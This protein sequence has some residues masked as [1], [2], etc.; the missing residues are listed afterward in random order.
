MFTLVTTV[1]GV[2]TVPVTTVW[3]AVVTPTTTVLDT[4]SNPCKAHVEVPP[5][6]TAVCF[7]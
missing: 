5:V 1:C 7:V 6:T 2:P 4:V 3:A